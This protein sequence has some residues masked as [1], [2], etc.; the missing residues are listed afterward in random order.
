VKTPPISTLLDRHAA[1][2]PDAPFLVTDGATYHYGDAAGRVA[3]LR[4]L[5]AHR[6]V[7]AG[8]RALLLAPNGPQFVFGWLALAGL[9]ATMVPVHS[10]LPD[11]GLR[12]VVED[13]GATWALGTP[14]LLQERGDS[15]SGIEPEHRIELDQRS[16]R[17]NGGG[18]VV[19]VAEAEHPCSILYTSGTT[20]PPKGVVLGHRAYF[21]SAAVMADGLGLGPDDR[22]LTALPLFHAN[23]QFY[24]LATALHAGASIAVVERFK[25]ATFLEDAARLGA[26][27]FT[28][29]GTILAM[30]AKAG[31]PTAEHRVRFCVGGGAP[32]P[33]WR[34]LESWGIRVHELYGST[35]TAGFVTLNTTQASREE[36]CGRVRDDFEVSVVDPDDNP[37]PAGERGE[38]VVRPGRPSVMFDGYHG[39][40]EITLQRMRNLWLHT[41]DA[42][43]ID[44]DGFLHFAGRLDHR[45]RRG[46]ENVDTPS[47]EA[48]LNQHPEVV[49]AAVVGVPDEIMGEEIKAVLVA[50]PDFDP[51]SLPDF[52][53]GRL[54][55]LA[56]PRYV[57]LRDA[58]PKTSTEK[59]V[60][61]ELRHSEDTVVDLRGDRLTTTTVKE[62]K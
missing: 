13:S 29:V 56:W 54:P 42:G 28:Y 38:I 33:V 16:D 19:S 25:A 23:P 14:E 57:E 18:L 53:K 45:V 35:E 34:E 43:R 50:S 44:A 55:R 37:L 51:W 52:L 27:G 39:Q 30:L 4:R 3:R 32:G 58:L 40:P 17:E 47:V 36:T 2:R 62:T 60:V 49:E 24:A 15:L 11:D 9:D 20:G 48:V 5:L 7:R 59:I 21:A 46:G 22:I 26:T 41:G 61:S 12:R 8:D 1:E 10:Q 31:R 6:G